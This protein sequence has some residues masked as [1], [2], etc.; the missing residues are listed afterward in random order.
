[1]LID[2]YQFTLIH[3][4]TICY[5]TFYL[6]SETCLYTMFE[7]PGKYVYIF[8]PKITNYQTHTVYTRSNFY[9]EDLFLI[10]KLVHMIP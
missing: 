10:N 6:N 1:M 2:F 3:I 4:P 8:K 5:I 7:H 9:Y